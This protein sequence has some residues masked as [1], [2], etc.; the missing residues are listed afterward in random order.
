MIKTCVLLLTGNLQINT[1]KHRPAWYP[2]HLEFPISEA[3]RKM[4]SPE[5]YRHAM[6]FFQAD[7]VSNIT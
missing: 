4:N 1:L 3:E 5:I 6:E 2:T 7:L